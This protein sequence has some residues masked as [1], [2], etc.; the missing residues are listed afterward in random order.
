M[1]NRWRFFELGA[2]VILIIGGA[3]L[4][5]S[6]SSNRSVSSEGILLAGAVLF[7][8]GAMMAVAAFRSFLW[9]RRMIHH[10]M[11]Q[12]GMHRSLHSHRSLLHRHR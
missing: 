7:A 10:A 1:M 9:H 12:R 6:G 4:L 2:S 3:A 8:C 5:N 11:P